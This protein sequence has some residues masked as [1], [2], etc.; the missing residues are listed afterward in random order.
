MKNKIRL[1]MLM[2]LTA[3]IFYAFSVSA[4]NI[5]SCGAPIISEDT[6]VLTQDINYNGTAGACLDI[7]ANNTILDCQGHTISGNG[8]ANE[9]LGIDMGGLSQ[10]VTNVIVKDCIIKDFGAYGFRA[11]NQDGISLINNT[12]ENTAIKLGFSIMV[13]GLS[14]KQYSDFLFEGNKINNTNGR[15]AIWLNDAQDIIIRNNE[16]RFL[17]LPVDF[18]T[19]NFSNRN[20]LIEGNLVEDSQKGFYLNGLVSNG[21]VRDNTLRD[22]QRYG[23]FI[24]TSGS[25]T[26]NHSVYNNLFEMTN[27]TLLNN[28]SFFYY[29]WVIDVQKCYNC[30]V[31]NNTLDF[32]NKW[33]GIRARYG[34]GDVN[35]YDNTAHG[36]YVGIE[37]RDKSNA[38]VYGNTIYEA[39]WSTSYIGLYD[40]FGYGLRLRSASDNNSFLDNEVYDSRGGFFIGTGTTADNTN[41]SDNDLY[42]NDVGVLFEGT[43]TL[44]NLVIEHNNVYDNTLQ[45]QSSFVINFT[46]NYYGDGAVSSGL[47]FCTAQPFNEGNVSDYSAYCCLS[48]WVGGCPYSTSA[49]NSVIFGAHTGL[50]FGGTTYDDDLRVQISVVAIDIDSSVLNCTLY[51]DYIN[52]DTGAV[53]MGFPAQEYLYVLNNTETFESVNFAYYQEFNDV[54]PYN[55]T[56]SCTDGTNT[57]NSTTRTATLRTFFLYDEGDIAKAT[58][59]VFAKGVLAI[60]LF[61]TI[62]LMVVGFVFMEKQL[63]KR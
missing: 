51:L 58:I 14:G 54:Q 55:L 28:V 31:Y 32:R 53:V 48:G 18:S 25:E 49:P 30:D 46:G 27:S 11:F 13:G 45:A 33:G 17:T 5:S 63:G 47:G 2:L 8:L 42:E 3:F 10:Y 1:K 29:D 12:F 41:V 56:F 9:S 52:V 23:V 43:S 60:G 6:Y 22:V 4:V 7:M 26:W 34:S 57:T 35:I 15:T 39:N 21:T 36:G 37:L 40:S 62:I 20:V 59:N 19:N 24:S 50:L 61:V 44:T 38:N 16:F